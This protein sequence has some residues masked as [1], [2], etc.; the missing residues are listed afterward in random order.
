MSAVGG[1]DRIVAGVQEARERQLA[2]VRPASAPVAPDPAAAA[3]VAIPPHVVAAIARAAVEAY[4]EAQRLKRNAD[5]RAY[6]AVNRD[7]INARRTE[8]RRQR[9]AEQQRHRLR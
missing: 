9:A 3:P 8:L 7:R 6:A 2:L 5:W 4:I 1:T